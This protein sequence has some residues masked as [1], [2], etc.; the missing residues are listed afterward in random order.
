MKD[1]AM[2]FEYS[3]GQ[4]G[5][6]LFIAPPPVWELLTGMMETCEEIPS[7]PDN[8]RFTASYRFYVYCERTGDFALN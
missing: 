1:P 3:K 8:S 5:R 6:N 2:S 7:N 4:G